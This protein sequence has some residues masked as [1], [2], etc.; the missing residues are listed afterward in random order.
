MSWDLGRLDA[1]DAEDACLSCGA[2]AVTFVDADERD[3]SPVLEPAP[4]EFRLW[5]AARV[6]ALF[7]PDADC[8]GIIRALSRALAVDPRLLH[9]REVADRAWER[10]WLRDFHAMRFGRRLWVCPHHEQVTEPQ[11]AV[12]R[13]DPGL[14]FGTGTHPTTALCLEWLDAHPPVDG[15]VVDFG[16][17]SGVL[18]LAALRLGARSASCFDIDSQALI[19]TRDNASANGLSERLRLCDSAGAIPRGADLLLA[20]ILSGP[21]VQLAG[22]FTDILAPSGTLVLSGLMEQEVPEVTCAY[23]AWFDISTFGVRENW[24]C[25]WA[26]RNGRARD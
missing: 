7:P 24:V 13:M 19:A 12:V 25:L 17:G 22:R 4:G 1:E 3:A 11:A 15:T 8:D 21:L 20:N 23:E 5:S 26:R 16:C 6:R 10:E 14:A 2:I 18:A 9:A